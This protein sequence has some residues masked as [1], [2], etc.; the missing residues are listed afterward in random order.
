MTTHTTTRIFRHQKH[1]FTTKEQSTSHP[2]QP[3]TDKAA[4]TLQTLA[5]KNATRLYAQ[6]NQQRIQTSRNRVINIKTHYKVLEAKEME[7]LLTQQE[8]QRQRKANPTFHSKG[9]GMQW[10]CNEC[11]WKNRGENSVCGGG[12]VT[13]GCGARYPIKE[14]AAMKKSKNIKRGIEASL[15]DSRYLQYVDKKVVRHLK[16]AKPTTNAQQPTQSK[17][18]V[19]RA[20]DSSLRFLNQDPNH[21]HTPNNRTNTNN[22][23][24]YPPSSLF[25]LERCLKRQGRVATQKYLQQG[26]VQGLATIEHCRWAFMD[27]HLCST[28][29]DQ[30]QLIDQMV[31]NNIPIDTFILNQLID[32]LLFEDK[33]QAANNVLL[34]YFSKHNVQPNQKTHAILKNAEH[35]A[36]MGHTH[37]L[38]QTLQKQGKAAA[39]RYL[40]ALINNE[41]ANTIH[42]NWMMKEVCQTSKEQRVIIRLM[43]EKNISVNE[44][45]LTQ[46][47]HNL[48][49]ENKQEEA[50]IVIDDDFQT[51]GL[52]HDDIFFQAIANSKRSIKLHHMSEMKQIMLTGSG[53]RAHT[54][55]IH[56]LRSGQADI[57]HCHWGIRHLCSTSMQARE[58]IHLMQ[59]K[60]VPVDEIILNI[61]IQKLLYEDSIE[62]AQKVIDIDFKKYGSIPTKKTHDL[63]K[64]AQ[65]IASRGHTTNMKRLLSNEKIHEMLD[66]LSNMNMTQLKERAKEIGMKQEQYVDF[67]DFKVENKVEN[68][69]EKGNTQCNNALKQLRMLIRTH[70]Q[71]TKEKKPEKKQE[72]KQDGREKSMNYLNALILDGKANTIHCNWG[73]T[74]LCNT[75]NEVQ[76][77]IDK[78]AYKN[79]PITATIL[80]SFINQLLFEGKQAAGKISC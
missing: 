59:K 18:V 51:Y 20:V 65:D 57:I 50:Q 76:I 74:E 48:I 9:P 22:G 36:A 8:D 5:Q 29:E 1:H 66:N 68:K 26:I 45:T 4:Q 53:V 67:V 80:N 14:T 11:S 58:V 24:G 10:T 33:Q 25:K 23:D 40:H 69:V 7:T 49:V 54:Y 30:M 52:I 43:N 77:L 46:L 38:K 56:I 75:S 3:T 13:Y 71:T 44:V 27:G 37:G 79:V 31:D 19:T 41:K 12:S 55:F 2:P 21:N 70:N 63:M 35:L 62:D 28:S 17:D 39:M 73:I 64:Q 34:N 47:I 61:L 32:K 78:M 6:Q 72:K 15:N 42:C 16:Q 60:E